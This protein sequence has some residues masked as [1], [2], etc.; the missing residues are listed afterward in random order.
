M[1]CYWNGTTPWVKPRADLERRA[2]RKLSEMEYQMR[3]WYYFVWTCGDHIVEQHIHNLDVINWI[4]NDYPEAAQGQGGAQFYRD[5]DYY[6]EIFDHHFVEFRY[7]NEARP[8]PHVGVIAQSVPTQ[9]L[10][11]NTGEGPLAISLPDTLGYTIAAVRGLHSE[12]RELEAKVAERDE[13]IRKLE[14]RL[15]SL[16]TKLE[17]LAQP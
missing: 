13:R 2:G 14:E 7:K 11:P 15:S 6:G 3:N 16:E 4:M 1:R 17:G 5:K 10:A 12:T 8:Q 9:L